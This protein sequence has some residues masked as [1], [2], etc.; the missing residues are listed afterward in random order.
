MGKLL[1]LKQT[2]ALITL[3]GRVTSRDNRKTQIWYVYVY[4]LTF[5]LGILQSASLAY[6]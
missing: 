6:T 3:W 1:G 4:W 2:P 5:I